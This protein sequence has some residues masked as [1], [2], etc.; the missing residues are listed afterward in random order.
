MIR[1]RPFISWMRHPAVWIPIVILAAATAILWYSGIDLAV[2]KLF[3]SG[4]VSHESLDQRWPLKVAQPWKLLYDWGVY[5]ALL[6][7]CGGLIVWIASFFWNALE[8]WRDPGLFFALTLIVGPGILVNAVMKPYWS[9]PRPHATQ[10]FGGPREFVPVGERGAGEDDSSFP[11][12]HAAMG[13]YLMSPAFVC[14]RRR[15]FWAVLF[16]LLGLWS[17]CV[18]GLARIVAGGHFVSDV[19]WAGG[20]VYFAALILALPF[21]FGD[22]GKKPERSEHSVECC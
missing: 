14:Y 3:F 17:G 22:V 6:L 9:R 19:L 16:L 8:R 2:A 12:G 13:F 11:S 18:M 20:V 10:E 4:N 7:G 15:R 21:R 1:V 5:P